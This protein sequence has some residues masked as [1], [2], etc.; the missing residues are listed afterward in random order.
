MRAPFI[1]VIP[2]KLLHHTVLQ[3]FLYIRNAHIKYNYSYIDEIFLHIPV[4]D[5]PLSLCNRG[6][7]GLLY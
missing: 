2:D 6:L 4:L 7:A 3:Y 5:T 1:K